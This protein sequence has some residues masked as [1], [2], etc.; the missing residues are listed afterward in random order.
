MRRPHKSTFIERLD[1][2]RLMSSTSVDFAGQYEVVKSGVLYDVNITKTATA[3]VYT[4]TLWADGQETS[5]NGTESNSGILSGHI[6][7]SIGQVAY[8]ASLSGK[9]LT[10][11]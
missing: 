1:S 7:S 3:G 6:A 8:A 9:S 4:G 2:R 11:E 5:F 10:V